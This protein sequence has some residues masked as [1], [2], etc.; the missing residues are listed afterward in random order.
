MDKFLQRSGTVQISRLV[1]I[2]RDC[3]HTGNVNNHVAAQ[4]PP[5]TQHHNRNP[6]IWLI[7]GPSDIDME[8]LVYDTK[9]LIQHPSLGQNN[10]CNGKQ[11]WKVKYGLENACALFHFCKKHRNDHRYKHQKRHRHHYISQC[12]PETVSEQ[13]I[14][15]TVFLRQ[16]SQVV[17]QTYKLRC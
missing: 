12:V 17:F 16:Q 2:F 9:A 6:E 7:H 4:A 14:I 1:Q 3:G 8:Q 13:C 15:I 10:G 5:Q 11:V